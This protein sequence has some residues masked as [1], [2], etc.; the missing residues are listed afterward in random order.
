[1]TIE[2]GKAF[3]NA[4]DGL[5]AIWYD[6]DGTVHFSDNFEEDYLNALN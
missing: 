3:V 1:M 4:I 2:E 6:I 5:E